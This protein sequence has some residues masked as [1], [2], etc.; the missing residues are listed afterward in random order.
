MWS[1][2]CIS[3][4]H[5]LSDLHGRAPSERWFTDPSK[6]VILVGDI[7]SDENDED[8]FKW[9]RFLSQYHVAFIRGNHDVHDRYGWFGLYGCNGNVL[10]YGKTLVA[11]LGWNGEKFADLPGTPELLPIISSLDR[12]LTRMRNSDDTLI[13]ATHY[14]PLMVPFIRENP[15]MFDEFYEERPGS[16]AVLEAITNWKPNYVVMGHIHQWHGRRFTTKCGIEFISSVVPE[17]HKKPDK[18]MFQ[19]LKFY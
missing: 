1:T 12:Q 6:N 7:L 16:I 18:R 9:N 13:L 14:P 5:F 10:R 8:S 11:C 19:P 3:G 2:P 17:Y 4:I 15:E